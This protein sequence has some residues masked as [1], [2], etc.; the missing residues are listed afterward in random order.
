MKLNEVNY[1]NK[2]YALYFNVLDA[3]EGLTFLSQDS[4]FIQVG[5]WNYLPK[6]ILQAHYH[7]DF[8]REAQLTCETIYVVS[9]LLRCN[10][11]TKEGNFIE[12]FE[13]GENNMAVQLY[14]A[15][16]YEILEKAIVIETKNGPYF[17]P[18][19][20]RTRIIV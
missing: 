11:Y 13:L 9:G 14:G 6:K 12:S 20:D 19:K 7:N 18:E 10:L 1:E 5:I 17:G 3:D 16:E 15:H 8:S 4:D 2:T